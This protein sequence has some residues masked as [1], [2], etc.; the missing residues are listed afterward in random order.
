MERI[1]IVDGNDN[2]IG[3]EDK[4]KCHNGNGILHRGFLA[5]VLNADGELL[6]ARRSGEKKLWPGFWDGTVAS[7]VVAGEG[8][9]EASKRRLVQE[10]GLS[11]DNIKY[12]FKF[13]Y[14][15]RYKDAGSESEICAVTLVNGVDTETIFPN[16]NEITSVRMITLRALV[17]EI[18]KDPGAYTPWLILALEHMNEQGFA[19]S[20]FRNREEALRI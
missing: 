12:L 15:A 7:H 19:I 18:T 13:Q 9:I 17:E 6:L 8:Y 5:M 3:E 1:V 14:H 11:T 16:S 2:P 4:D 10:I 20:D